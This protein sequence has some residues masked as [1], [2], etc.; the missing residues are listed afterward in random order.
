MGGD[1]SNMVSSE[2]PH[3]DVLLRYFTLGSYS[4]GT[5]LGGN[6]NILYPNTYEDTD[7]A[8]S[9]HVGRALTNA[10]PIESWG[11]GNFTSPF[12]LIYATMR[13]YSQKLD[14]SHNYHKEN[15]FADD[16]S[17]NYCYGPF[18][19]AV[20]K[21]ESKIPNFLISGPTHV[22]S[23]MLSM[24]YASLLNLLKSNA[25][26]L[27]N[28]I[29]ESTN[30]KDFT[31]VWNLIKLTAPCT[32]SVDFTWNGQ[33]FSPPMWLSAALTGPSTTDISHTVS[34]TSPATT[35]VSPVVTIDSPRTTDISHTVT[36]T[37]PTTTSLGIAP[38]IS[39]PSTISV[40]DNVDDAIAAFTARQDLQYAEEESRLRGTFFGARAC[41]SSFFDGALANLTAQKN[42]QIASFEESLRTERTRQQLQADSDY[43]RNL[44][45]QR[46][47][48][49]Q[50]DAERNQ[51]AVVAHQK[52]VDQLLIQQSKQNE[53]EVDIA[54]TQLQA[55]IEFERQLLDR[56][57]I[58]AQLEL[59]RTH[60]E[61]ETFLKHVDQLLDKEKSVQQLE[62]DKAKSQLQADIEHERL[63]VD[64]N[65]TLAQLELEILTLYSRIW[66]KKSDLSQIVWS[67]ELKNKVDT[68]STL[69]QTVVSAFGGA[70]VASVINTLIEADLKEDIYKREN[71]LA[72][73]SSS[74]SQ[75]QTTAGFIA[76][77]AELKWKSQIQDLMVIKEGLSALT[78]VN[79]GTEHHPSRFE[80][81][82]QG[83]SAGLGAVSTVANL[84]MI[85][86]G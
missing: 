42:A 32:T 44:L 4:N 29:I 33:S 13:A 22:P 58:K 11:L 5:L 72:W 84:G 59:E 38:S 31:D 53:I 73:V 46:T 14:L 63:S 34:I 78:G 6:S 9:Y 21:L 24:R 2:I 49:A 67:T 7:G 17:I 52:Y 3:N 55:D 85:L 66:E 50:L 27:I 28:E 23:T 35:T 40:L 71:E 82:T 10:D 48:Q 26:D 19:W 86:G 68:L 76:N 65:K 43:Q 56:N 41:M 8:T 83:I 39:T 79:A 18:N 69:Y 12:S 30:G 75:L 36:L 37:P 54:K 77:I 20:Q 47:R 74:I 1:G 70:S 45:E 57:K 80:V 62:L 51:L 61:V 60:L 15:T 81:I 25:S 16:R 64:T